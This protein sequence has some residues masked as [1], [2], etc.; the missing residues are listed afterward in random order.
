MALL[1]SSKLKFWDTR[2]TT[3]KLTRPSIR[4]S[5]D[6]FCKCVLVLVTTNPNQK[7]IQ[8]SQ[9]IILIAFLNTNWINSSLKGTYSSTLDLFWTWKT[10]NVD[11]GQKGIDLKNVPSLNND[12]C[13]TFENLCLFQNGAK[14]ILKLNLYFIQFHEIFYKIKTAICIWRWTYFAFQ[15]ALLLKLWHCMLSRRQMDL[16]LKE[17][18]CILELQM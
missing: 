16:T 3:N 11:Q 17:R 6:K 7:K 2:R 9:E 8:H 15:L 4:P 1:T 13:H 18:K 10:K 12:V 14:N 5:V